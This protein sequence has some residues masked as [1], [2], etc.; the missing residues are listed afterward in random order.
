MRNL[1][2]VKT[3]GWSGR[4][5][6]VDAERPGP[7]TSRAVAWWRVMLCTVAL[8]NLVLWSLSAAAQTHRPG[9]GAGAAG[10]AQLIL[11]AVYVVGCAF[12]S[13]LPVYDIPRIVLIDS[14][15]SGIFIGRSVATVAELCFAA[16][17]ALMLHRI[18]AASGSTLGQALAWAI[19]PLI[20]VAEVGS[21]YSVLTTEQRGHILENS[22]WGIA[23]ALLGTG[24]WVAGS[25]R[26]QALYP[27]MIA[28]CIGAAAYAAFL[29]CFDVPMYWSRWRADRAAGRRYLKLVPGI[30]DAWQRRVVSYRW[31][32]WKGEMLW[33][34]LY[35]TFG[36][37]SSISLVYG[38]RAL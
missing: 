15:L 30:A 2:Q 14:R 4:S 35:F 23:A 36:V 20:V 17:W 7:L 18:A 27:F 5:S 22:L 31:E 19:M 10:H 24:L 37:W 8:L 3:G 33:M 38:S 26:A 12:R 21:W 34:S 28:W 11:S 6:G 16:Q 9:S 25:G 13:V 29:F 1:A 32:D